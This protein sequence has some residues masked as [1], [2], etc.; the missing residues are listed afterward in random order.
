M[1]MGSTQPGFSAADAALTLIGDNGG[2]AR[3]AQ[4]N[5][6]YPGRGRAGRHF[7]LQLPPQ[8]PRRLDRIPTPLTC[9]DTVM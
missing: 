5:T 4:M 2:Y 8:T 1:V 7:H 9:G 3:L 6:N